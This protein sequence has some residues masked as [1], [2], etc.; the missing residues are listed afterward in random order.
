MN[1]WLVKSEPAAYSWQQ[2]NK[3]GKTIWDG[4]RNYQARNNL[5]KMQKGDLLLFYHSVTEKQVMGI[6]RVV[7]EHYPDPSTEDKRWSVVDIVP[8][9]TLDKPVPLSVIKADNRLEHIAL[10]KQSRLSVMPL[11]AE[12]FDAII[13]LGSFSA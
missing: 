11:S 5:R 13:D 2:F 12:A 7:R 9:K 6:A 10:I 4:V 1:Y 3:D 8:E